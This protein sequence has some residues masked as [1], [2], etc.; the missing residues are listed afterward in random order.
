MPV[1]GKEVKERTGLRT[2]Q[3]IAAGDGVGNSNF[4]GGFTLL[5]PG[6][7]LFGAPLGTGSEQSKL[8]GAKGEDL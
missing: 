1:A 2:V 6:A 7:M 3:R 5:R 8:Y 4:S